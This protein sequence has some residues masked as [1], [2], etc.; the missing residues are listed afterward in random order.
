MDAER[1]RLLSR[2]YEQACSLPTEKRRAFLDEA[3]GSDQSLRQDL[4]SLLAGDPPADSLSTAPAADQTFADS[5]R[6][7]ADTAQGVMEAGTILGSYRIEG[8]LGR[9]GMGL[10]YRAHDTKLGR[11]VA[12]KT[13]RPSLHDAGAVHRFQREA[14]ALAKVN[15]PNICQIYEIGEAANQPF[16]AMELLEGES[17]A[18][19]LERGPLSTIDA[20]QTTTAILSALA[21]LHGRHFVHRDVK[22]SNVFLAPHGVKLLDFGLA[23][24]VDASAVETQLALTQ[25]GTI[26]GTHQ[27]MAP[28]QLLGEPVDERADLFA[29]G[30]LLFESIAGKRPFAGDSIV[31]VLHAILRED[32]PS[33]VGSAGITAVDRIVR[34]ALAKAPADRY[35]SADEM[36]REL[37]A[38][39]PLV[40]SASAR[41]QST[42]RLAVLPFRVLRDDPELESLAFGLA[43]ALTTALTGVESL[44]VRSSLLCAR[45]AGE[46]L[47]LKKLGADLDIDSVLAGVILGAGDRIRVSAQL[48]GVADG[49]VMWSRA[50]EVLRDEL[51]G[52]EAELATAVQSALGLVSVHER[53]VGG[54]P[55]IESI[56]VLPLDNLSGDREQDYFADGMTDALI[57]DLAK[58]PGLKRVIAR[59]SVMRYRGSHKP[60]A[61]IAQELRVDAL[62]TGAVLRAGDRVRITAQLINPATEEQLWADRYERDLHDVLP[63]QNEILATIASQIKVKLTRQDQAR[64]ATAQRVNPE[65]Y[66]LCLKGRFYADKLSRESFDMALEHY[67]RALEKEPDYAPA[68]AGIGLTLL[69]RAHMGFLPPSEGMA[70]GKAAALKAIALDDSFADVHAQLA[71]SAYYGEW[72]WSATERALQRALDLNPNLSIGHQL[73]AELLMLDG[74]RDEAAVALDRCLELDPLNPWTQTAVGGRYLRIDRD[75]EGVALLEKALRADPNLALAHQYLATAFHKRGAFARAVSEA[76]IFLALKG[77]EDVADALGRNYDTEGYRGGMRRAAESLAARASATYV[78]PTW[79]AGFY[80]FADDEARA[81]EWLERAYEVRDSWLVFLPTDPRFSRLRGDSRFTDL[82]RRMNIGVRQE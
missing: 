17:L 31:A 12:I 82:L 59:G 34:R 21:V 6:K 39:A 77:H 38:V 11:E 44:I 76:R 19:R 27:Y 51:M 24:Q 7:P 81:F 64:L 14:R 18:A 69:A 55:P 9:G 23:R 54:P 2:I 8:L 65:A 5:P 22:P 42:T 71:A 40:D 29:V 37:H 41:T 49:K 63:L 3:W 74:R 20:I 80:A 16:I 75:D 48:L 67:Q 35:G 52:L 47:D 1:R 10:V 57:T 78:Q 25:S 70:A 28:E 73:R 79:V 46:P 43:D 26:V 62:V 53:R 60:L 50:S 15:H 30:V 61:K 68:H 72:D 13:L 33:L 4:E 58:L 56:A 36:A 32:P 66:E 45:F